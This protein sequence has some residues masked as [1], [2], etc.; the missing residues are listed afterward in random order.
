MTDATHQNQPPIGFGE[1]FPELFFQFSLFL[2]PM[3]FSFLPFS[4]AISASI[5]VLFHKVTF[6]LINT[7]L[8]WGLGAYPQP[9]LKTG[10]PP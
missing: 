5:K 9:V 8:V 6:L 2:F 4:F 7:E 3:V 1:L 10:I